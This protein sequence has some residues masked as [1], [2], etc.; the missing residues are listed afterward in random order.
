MS[1][2]NYNAT[3]ITYMFGADPARNEGT[4]QLRYSRPTYKCLSK[5]QHTQSWSLLC[6][7]TT[8][9]RT[10]W[11]SNTIHRTTLLGY[12]KHVFLLHS[13][14]PRSRDVPCKHRGC[15]WDPVDLDDSVQFQYYVHFVVRHSV[16]K[17]VPPQPLQDVVKGCTRNE[18]H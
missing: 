9:L 18:V 16:L 10:S 7:P 12:N 17:A 15:V 6:W 8:A 2:K 3:Q 14:F 5:A 4:P 11:N 1:K 13:D